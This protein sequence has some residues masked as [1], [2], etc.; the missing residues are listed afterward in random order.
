MDE[1]LACEVALR[2]SG[3]GVEL[4]EGAV[5]RVSAGQE[6][7]VDEEAPVEV[8]VESAEAAPRSRELGGGV[9]RLFS[10]R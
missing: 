6:E 7:E 5:L 2:Q 3:L 9:G 1:A 8:E 10:Q 4:R